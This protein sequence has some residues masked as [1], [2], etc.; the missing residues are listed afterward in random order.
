MEI[1]S[2]AGKDAENNPCKAEYEK[3]RMILRGE[4]VQENTFV[5]IRE[6][7]EGDDV[8]NVEHLKKANPVL[9]FPNEYSAGLLK[10]IK[11][12]YETAYGTGDP[13]KI[14]EYLTKRCNIWQ[15]DSEEKYLSTEQLNIWREL[16][17]PRDEFLELLKGCEHI[18]GYDL[19]KKIDLT[20]YG[21]VADLPDGRVAVWAHGFIPEDSVT[22]H[23]KRDRVPYA[24]WIRNGWVT[25]TDGAVV[26]Y[27]AVTKYVDECS[28]AIGSLP[29]E[30]CFD[31]Y[32][33]TY[34]MTEMDKKQGRTPVEIK[35]T[36]LILSEPT[37]RLRELIVSRK[38]VHDGSPLLTWA[39]GNAY[40]YT[41]SN[42][43]IKL[44]KKNKDDSQRID[45]A[46]AVVNALARLPKAKSKRSKYED[47][48]L[49]IL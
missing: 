22:A 32:N 4:M 23:Q 18:A 29:K 41:D 21:G 15:Q 14:R 5:M 28:L 19:S 2:T 25:K 39:L 9:Q 24:D 12:E 3:G 46:A 10:T 36:T 40:A 8:S 38:V 37:N 31:P 42:G 6:L 49:V 47:D 20:A 17:V 30:D 7:E 33:A 11:E 48:D 13:D 45:P 35:Q 44:S 16:A 43:N 26:D 34:Y 1:I 27:D